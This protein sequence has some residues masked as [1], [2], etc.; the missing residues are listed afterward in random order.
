MAAPCQP[1]TSERRKQRSNELVE[2]ER[3]GRGG[4]GRGRREKGP[5]RTKMG[6]VEAELE[7]AKGGDE[8]EKTD[9]TWR[10]GR[11]KQQQQTDSSTYPFLP[12]TRAA[13]SFEPGKFDGRVNDGDA[14]GG[15]YDEAPEDQRREKAA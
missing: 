9:G 2:R 10:A 15:N 11:H 3:G 4:E 7:T 14:N 5:R 1:T 6:K 8:G 13:A 12:T